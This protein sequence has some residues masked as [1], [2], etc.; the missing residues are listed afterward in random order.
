MVGGRRDVDDQRRP[1]QRLLTGRRAGLP[2]VLAH[3]QPHARGAQVDV[4]AGAARLEIALLIED[5]VVGQVDLA[6]DRMHPS[7]C[8]NGGGVVDVLRAL[9][10]PDHR[11]RAA[12][13]ACE[14]AQGRRRA[15]EEVLA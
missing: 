2:D 4:C 12:G 15:G 14:L 1:R 11:H 7:A 9:G 6:I 3:R 5:A 8:Q 13:F 10:E